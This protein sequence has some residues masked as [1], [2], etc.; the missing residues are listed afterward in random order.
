MRFL[1]QF[2]YLIHSQDMTPGYFQISNQSSKDEDFIPSWYSKQSNAGSEGT[3]KE[4]MQKYSGYKVTVRSHLFKHLIIQHLLSAHC[5]R[6][7]RI[8]YV[9]NPHSDAEILVCLLKGKGKITLLYNHTSFM[10]C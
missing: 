8:F 3:S 7:W 5:A 1:K 9:V 4:E 10:A 6:Y 2:H